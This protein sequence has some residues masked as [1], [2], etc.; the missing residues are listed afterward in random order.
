MLKLTFITEDNKTIELPSLQPG[1][2]A[3]MTDYST[4]EKEILVVFSELSYSLI[5]ISDYDANIEIGPF[6]VTN[7]LRTNPEKKLKA[8]ERYERPFQYK[9]KKGKMVFEQE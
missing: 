7:A 1:Q 9:T 6:R 8:G 5:C 2:S 4:P 3:S